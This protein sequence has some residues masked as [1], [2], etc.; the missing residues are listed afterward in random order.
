MLFVISLICAPWNATV[1]SRA[2]LYIAFDMYIKICRYK[3]V[4]V[5]STDNYM[6]ICTCLTEGSCTHKFLHVNQ[7]HLIY[8]IYMYVYIYI[9]IYMCV[10][11]HYVVVPSIGYQVP[12]RD[13][14]H[15][16]TF[17]ISIGSSPVN[18]G[19]YVQ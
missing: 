12:P 15:F 18:I 8:K 19:K 5:K 1:W 11:I 3:Y 4:K 7:K 2:Y 17:R 13:Q 16:W 6:Y 10:C 9:Y 14:R